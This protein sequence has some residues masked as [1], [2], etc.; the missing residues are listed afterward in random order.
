MLS[1]Y[2]T[3]AGL[4]KGLEKDFGKDLERTWKVL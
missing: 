3:V 4:W 1:L 2:R